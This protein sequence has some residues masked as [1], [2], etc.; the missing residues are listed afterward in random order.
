MRLGI[1]LAA[2]WFA[3]V[4]STANAQGRDPR[5]AGRAV[6]T[7][8]EAAGLILSLERAEAQIK[9]DLGTNVFNGIPEVNTTQGRRSLG[10]VWAEYLDRAGY[11]ADFTVRQCLAV[12]F[13]AI[14][15]D[16]SAGFVLVSGQANSVA[17]RHLKSELAKLK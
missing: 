7:K 1:A 17:I 10:V 9:S 5:C 6:A 12:D 14:G 2:V 15:M 3:S 8:T 4:V 11:P 13:L 16:D